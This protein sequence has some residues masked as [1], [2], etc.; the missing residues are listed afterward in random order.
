MTDQTPSKF[1]EGNPTLQRAWDSSSLQDLMFCPR[2][3][4]YTQIEGWRGPSTDLEF[5]G[6]IAS[7]LEFYQKARLKGASRDEAQLQTLDFA[8]TQTWL[9]D[10][11]QWGGSYEAVWACEGTTKYRNAKGNVAKCPYSH[12]GK[13]FPAPAPDV[14][15]ECGSGVKTL[16]LYQPDNQIK[17]RLTL[18]RALV[19][20]IEDQPEELTDGLYPFTFP[21]GTPAVELSGRLPTPWTTPAGEPYILAFHLDYIGKFGEELFITDN[22]TT[23]HALNAAFWQG[24]SPSMQLDN[25][26]L[27]GSLL[28]PDLPIRGVMLDAIQ[29]SANSVRFGRHP[30]YKTESQREEQWKLI[31]WWIKQAERYAEEGFWPMNKRNCWQCMF[32][33][34]CSKPPEERAKWLAADFVKREPWNPLKER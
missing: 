11:R 3:Y 2:A 7:A 1:S 32:K 19:W 24:Y 20:Y 18:I 31:E 10:D 14:C 26:D 15:G 33:G 30:F 16:R 12:K 27:F 17:N 9:G 8:L 28:F 5:G 25:Y 22:K 4:Q 29:V 21:D 34:V 13:Y 6:Y 23:S